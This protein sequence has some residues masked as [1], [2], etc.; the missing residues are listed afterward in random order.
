MN[1][2]GLQKTSII[3]FSPHVCCV[4]FLGGCNF[5]CGFCHNPELVFELDENQRLSQK[6]IFDF[7]KR[8]KGWLDAVCITGGEPTLNKDLPE[9]IL[10]IKKLGY[11]VKLDSNGTNPQMLE[12]LFS[13]ELVD[14]VA[15]D[16]KSSLDK[17]NSV[18][19]SFVDQAKI[20]KSVSLIMNSGIDYEFRT[21]VV[22]ELHTK[23][24]FIKMAQWIKGAKRFVLQQFRPQ[25]CLNKK[26]EK[27]QPF[28]LQEIEE[29]KKIL[30]PYVQEVLSR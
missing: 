9:F 30:A 3:D 8:R 11:K 19:N 21:T 1:I 28:D 2:C 27:V 18:V 22:P 13:K 17:Y 12:G 24:D 29:F 6:E 5:R 14:Y 7:L 15:M 4:I 26:F 23:E 10:A 25:K 20:K 16:I